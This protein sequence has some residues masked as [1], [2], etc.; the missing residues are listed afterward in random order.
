[1]RKAGEKLDG[2]MMRVRPWLQDFSFFDLMPY[3]DAEVRA[4]I[5]AVEASGASGWMLWDPNN[6]YH[7]GALDP[8][9]TGAT[10][11]AATPASGT[12]VMATPDAGTPT[13]VPGTPVARRRW[14]PGVKR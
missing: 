1:M 9:P 10:P 13:S 5:E 8:D 6:R 4:Q 11:V 7:P 2:D 12:P 14:A 3:G